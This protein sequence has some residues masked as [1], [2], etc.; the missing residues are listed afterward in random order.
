MLNGD[1]PMILECGCH[2]FIVVSECLVGG[3]NMW[4]GNVRILKKCLIYNVLLVQWGS[5]CGTANRMEVGW[6]LKRVW[7]GSSPSLKFIT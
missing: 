6:V 4:I 7:A 2:E 5:E 3:F 1:G